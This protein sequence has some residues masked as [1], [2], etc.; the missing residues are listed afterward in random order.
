MRVRDRKQECEKEGDTRSQIYRPYS[1]IYWM[2]E[3]V[4]WMLD[5]PNREAI[6]MQM[7][8]VHQYLLTLTSLL[9]GEMTKLILC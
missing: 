2:D 3:Q 8:K 6:K 9:S 5:V 1:D 4:H 7:D